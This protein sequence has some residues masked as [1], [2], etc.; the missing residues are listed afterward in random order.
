M[1]AALSVDVTGIT[2]GL[3]ITAELYVDLYCI[4]VKESLELHRNTFGPAVMVCIH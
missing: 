2:V 3:Q 4:H 1:S